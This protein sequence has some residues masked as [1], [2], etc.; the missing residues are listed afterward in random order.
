MLEKSLSSPADSIAY[1]LED[2]V[3][4]NQK[5]EAR[6]LVSNLLNVN[7]LSYSPV[8]SPLIA[9][10]SIGLMTRADSLLGRKATERRGDGSDQCLWD[11]IGTG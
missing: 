10:I 1:D 8:C 6:R 3:A 4:Q 2:A 5:V 7:L 9:L 11:G